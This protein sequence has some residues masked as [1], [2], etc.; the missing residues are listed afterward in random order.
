M[1]VIMGSLQGLDK[2]ETAKKFGEDKVL[3]W[4]RSFNIQPPLANENSEF[5]PNNDDLYKGID[6]QLPLG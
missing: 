2:L 1:N 5:D 6:I 3:Q 4:R